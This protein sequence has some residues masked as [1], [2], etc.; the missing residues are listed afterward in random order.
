[1]GVIQDMYLDSTHKGREAFS[2][3][4]ALL[5][6][7]AAQTKETLIEA[8]AEALAA[9]TCEDARGWFVHSGYAPWGRPL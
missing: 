3:V 9:A 7:A 4:K 5:K 2:K 8:I 1:M 6:K